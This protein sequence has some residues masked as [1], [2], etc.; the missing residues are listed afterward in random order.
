MAEFDYEN[1]GIVIGDYWFRMVWAQAGCLD[2]ILSCKPDSSDPFQGTWT[3]QSSV[4]C[5]DG[6]LIAGQIG[7]IIFCQGEF[8]VTWTPF[9]TFKDYW[10]TYNLNATTGAL[11]MT[12]VGGNNIPDDTDLTGTVEFPNDGTIIL[13]D[14]YFGTRDID[15]STSGIATAICGHVLE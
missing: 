1:A 13:R 14:I 11:T 9:E 6:S 10:G 2:S 8:S 7:E 12:V 5:E 3:E 15:A 4:A